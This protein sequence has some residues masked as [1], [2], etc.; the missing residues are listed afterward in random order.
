MPF[1]NERNIFMDNITGRFASATV[2]ATNIEDYA[3]AQIKMIL[4]KTIAVAKLDEAYFTQ[5][6]EAQ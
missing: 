6:D 2:F 5:L 4:D 3:G 1:H